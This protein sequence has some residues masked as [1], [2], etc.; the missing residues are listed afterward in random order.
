MPAPINADLHHVIDSLKQ[1]VVGQ[2]LQGRFD[3]DVA[4]TVE[5]GVGIDFQEA[6]RWA[7]RTCLDDHH[8]QG[9]VRPRLPYPEARRAL[10]EF[11]FDDDALLFALRFGG[12]VRG[13]IDVDRWRQSVI[14]QL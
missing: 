1:S 8:L 6:C 10:W 2:K 11:Q 12:T 3:F 9:L 13:P 4:V 7:L 5:T 14:D